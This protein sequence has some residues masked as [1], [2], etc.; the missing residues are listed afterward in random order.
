[1][2]TIKGN[3]LVVLL[4][5]KTIYHAQSHEVTSTSNFE[6]WET[7]DTDG[8]QNELSTITGSASANG[9]AC[10]SDTGDTETY[11]TPSL[12]DAQLAGQSVTLTLKLGTSTYT[13]TAWIESVS[14]TGEVS[15]KATYSASFKFNKLTKKTSQSS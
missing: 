10:I 4:D 11:D 1:M 15:K 7:K 12:L 5:D 8:V 9:I 6:E 2:K 13:G 14:A 3:D